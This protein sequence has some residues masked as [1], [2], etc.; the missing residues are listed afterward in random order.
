MPALRPYSAVPA[1]AFWRMLTDLLAL[2][3]LVLA[4]LAGLAVYH[5]V[6]SLEI[7]AEGLA[8]TGHLFDSVIGDFRRNVPRDIP[9]VSDS[10]RSLADALQRNSGDPLIRQAAVIHERVHTLAL[11]LGLVTAAVPVLV[12]LMTYGRTRWAEMREMGS[13][14][15]FVRAAV[16][17][18]R[19]QQAAAV[20]AYRAI[21]TLS[22]RELMRVS[23]DPVGDLDARS[24]GPLSRAMLRRAGLPARALG[25]EVTPSPATAASTPRVA[26]PA[27]HEPREE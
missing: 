3:W 9:F 2:A 26:G 19:E 25:D 8:K 16:R 14:A 5:V 23:A 1:R 7:I 4:I 21:A 17:G 24:Y 13:A 27:L 6:M 10:L 11:D 20:L 15:A 22:F 18:G 12:L